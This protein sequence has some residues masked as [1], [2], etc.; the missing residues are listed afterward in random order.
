MK[1]KAASCF[2]PMGWIALS[3]QALF[4]CM[5]WKALGLH[6]QV[7]ALHPARTF[8]VQKQNGR[9]LPTME[10]PSQEV[11]DGKDECNRGAGGGQCSC[12]VRC[13]NSRDGR[14]SEAWCLW[15]KPRATATEIS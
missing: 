7:L 15:A 6:H 11:C 4:L 9:P 2:A 8:L 10:P 14:A 5:G 3:W 13:C 12:Q 1:W